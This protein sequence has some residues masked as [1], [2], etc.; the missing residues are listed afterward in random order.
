MGEFW[1]WH[2]AQC[3]LTLSS[4]YPPPFC[5]LKPC[6]LLPSWIPLFFR[7]FFPANLFSSP[8]RHH[9][10]RISISSSPW[11][12]ARCRGLALPSAAELQPFPSQQRLLP[13]DYSGISLPGGL[14]LQQELLTCES[15]V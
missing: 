11:H 7:V 5:S 14:H 15:F 3:S 8:S 13:K 10:L 2:A 9:L 1:G 12:V 6:L 4:Q